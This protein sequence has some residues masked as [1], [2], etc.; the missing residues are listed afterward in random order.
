MK[1]IINF[2]CPRSGT[3]FMMECLKGLLGGSAH[4]LSE[5]N[6]CH[7]CQTKNG[8]WHLIKMFDAYDGGLIFI[9][10][11]RN[12]SEIIKS[13][14]MIRLPEYVS[15]FAIK[16]DEHMMRF[17]IN[18][19]LNF[20]SQVSDKKMWDNTP[21]ITI[22]YDRLADVSYQN[23]II[24]SILDLIG[25][26]KHF[27]FNASLL[28]EWFSRFNKKPVN[29]GRLQENKLKDKLIDEDHLQKLIAEYKKETG[30]K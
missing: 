27:L 7:P 11:V 28:Q 3:T 13:F 14:Y 6:P 5:G 1:H 10:T 25:V 20:R 9:R 8:L 22:N 4:K 24:K 15:K 26:G 19:E 18:E 21:I 12:I 16:T 29:I 17:I 30:P 23:Q 2:G